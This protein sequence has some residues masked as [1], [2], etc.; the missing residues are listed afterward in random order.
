MI[1]PETISTAKLIIGG[2]GIS[3][4]AVKAFS[5]VRYNKSNT[6]EPISFNLFGRFS[7]MEIDGSYTAK[8]RNTL[9][10][11]NRLTSLFYLSV[12]GFVAVLM[13]PILAEKLGIV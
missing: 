6:D 3:L 1:S 7:N 2:V 5:I 4:I 10:L 13:I 8:R 9:M 12:F 11:C